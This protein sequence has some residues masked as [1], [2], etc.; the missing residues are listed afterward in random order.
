MPFLVDSV[1][2]EVNRHGLTLH[3]IIHP[4]LAVERGAG[5]TL[6]GLAAAG[7]KD[8]RY[9]SFIHVEVDRI[10]EPARLEALAV[11][12]GNVLDDVRAAVEDWKP[13]RERVQAILSE[14]ESRAPPLPAD[15]RAEGKDFLRWLVDNHFTFLGYRRHELATVGGEDVLKVVPGSSLGFCAKARA[16][17]SRRASPRCL[18]GP[19][20]RAPAGAAGDHQGD[21]ALDVIGRAIW[22]TSRSSA[23]P[24]R[25][26]RRGPL[27][28]LF[29]STA[30]SANPLD[31][32]LLRRKTAN[33][34]SR[35]GSARA[36]TPARHWSTSSRPTLATSCSRSPRATCCAPRRRSCIWK[37][38]RGS[39]SSCAATPSSASCP[40]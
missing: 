22:T 34:C 6:S 38:G 14:L 23:S 18:R 17:R 35:R 12:I 28:R 10:V 16:R 5:G 3:L 1:T 27:P 31:I 19:G 11:D 9:E 21:V 37:S 24:G 40:A 13:M 30:Y 29:T 8:A 39:G 2:M 20:L 25:G 7:T 33:V 15:E 36:V 26:V 4:I 32:P